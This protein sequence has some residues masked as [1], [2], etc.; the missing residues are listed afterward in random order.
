MNTKNFLSAVLF[1]FIT[2]A[3]SVEKKQNKGLVVPQT[4]T[5]KLNF[6]TN[7]STIVLPVTID[8][9][10][11]NFIFDTGATFTTLQVDAVTGRSTKV[12]GADGKKVKVGIGTIGSFKIG[13]SDFQDTYTWKLPMDYLKQKVP[14]FGG[15]IG[16]S[17]ISKANWLIDYPKNTIEFTDKV[18]DTPN[19]ET[20]KVDKIRD[21]KLS[22]TLDGE[23][24]TALIDL[25]SSI[26]LVVPEGSKL[27]ERLLA[28]YPFKDSTRERYTV[29][30]GVQTI[31]EKV[32]VTPKIAVGNLVFDATETSIAASSQIR[33]GNTFFKDY[34]IYIDNTNGVY[35]L[36]K[37]R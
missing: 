35:K 6:T 32:G 21:P 25:G 16:Q 12:S 8:G 24:Y 5:T 37:T 11:Q 19:F 27:A 17:I 22:F 1:L 13:T 10:L 36:K 18:I 20:I 15:L 3:C 31:N 9:S 28:K 29:S 33:V 34:T 4:S 23:T 30:S 26:G 14:N 7:R 2:L